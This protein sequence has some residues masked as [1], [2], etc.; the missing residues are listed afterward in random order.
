MTTSGT[1]I[2][3]ANVEN[4]AYPSGTCAERVALGTAVGGMGLRRGDFR[5]IGVITDLG[6][7]TGGP[8]SPCGMCRQALREFLDLST[9]VF[10]FYKEEGVG[11]PVGFIVKTLGEL[12]PMSFGPDVLPSPDVMDQI[13]GKD[14]TGGMGG[15]SGGGGGG[16]MFANSM[17]S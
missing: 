2:P 11:V 5:A 10:M 16:G 12:L 7:K 8:A 6:R 13:Q 14:G 3:G 17:V 4:A 15:G 1:F 9:P